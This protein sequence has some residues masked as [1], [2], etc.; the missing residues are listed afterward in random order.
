MA[1]LDEFPHFGIR[2][3][4][5]LLTLSGEIPLDVNARSRHA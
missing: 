3:R 2:E 1:Q 5:V 4:A